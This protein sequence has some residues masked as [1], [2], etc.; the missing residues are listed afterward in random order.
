MSRNLR[1][2]LH[3]KLRSH[4]GMRGS[5]ELRMDAFA[6]RD[7]RA[8]IHSGRRACTPHA[9]IKEHVHGHVC[10]LVSPAGETDARARPWHSVGKCDLDSTIVRRDRRS[11]RR[12]S[13]GS[14]PHSMADETQ[15]RGGRVRPNKSRHSPCLESNAHNSKR[16]SCRRAVKN[17]LDGGGYVEIEAAAAPGLRT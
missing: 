14:R 10:D 2:H 6:K 5:S 8:C 7:E 17:E 13:R 11:R 4:S 1:D 3:S 12:R 15:K 9:H 16:H